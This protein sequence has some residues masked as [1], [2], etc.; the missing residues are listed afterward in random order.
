VNTEH[1]LQAPSFH[2]R[3]LEYVDTL[4][5]ERRYTEGRCGEF[6]AALASLTGWPIFVVVTINYAGV[7][8]TTPGLHAVVCN[9]SGLFVDVTGHMS[10]TELFAAW[11]G[12]RSRDEQLA[13]IPWSEDSWRWLLNPHVI[14]DAK[15]YIRNEREELT[16]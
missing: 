1:D 4:E 8:T 9:P 14:N 16:Q 11:D 2:A 7:V 10:Q 3:R 15:D 5:P 13:V 6:A 12:W